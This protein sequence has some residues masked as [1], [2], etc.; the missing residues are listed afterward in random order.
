MTHRQAAMIDARFRQACAAAGVS[1]SPKQY[2]K[3][4]HG[5]GAARLA[6]KASLDNHHDNQISVQA[7]K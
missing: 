7:T 2:R 1:P 5:R 3:W 4:V 6:A